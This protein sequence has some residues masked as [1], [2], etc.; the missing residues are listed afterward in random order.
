MNPFRG[1]IYL[2]DIP[3][4]G[5]SIQKFKRPMLVISNN[6]CNEHSTVIHLCPLTS[7]TTKSK[8]PTHVEIGVDN[9]LLF[10]SIALVEQSMLLSKNTLLKKIGQCSETVMNE[11][12]RA[13]MVQFGILNNRNNIK[14]A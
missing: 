14:Y 7:K 13:L 4:V 1:Q 3:D 8:L 10:P 12:D 2:V 6:L 9:G 5:G 11:V